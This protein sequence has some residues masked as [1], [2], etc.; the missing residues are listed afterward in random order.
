MTPPVPDVPRP[1]RQTAGPPTAG[2]R[3]A[4]ARTVL[5]LAVAAWVVLEIWLLTVVA[6]ALGGW[7]V[8]LL[9]LAGLVL[10]VAVVRRAGR[11]AWRR[12]AETVR[13]GAPQTPADRGGG[14]VTTMLGG[15]LLLLPG[16][17]SDVA[18]L[19]CLFPPTARLLRRAAERA[20]AGRSDPAPGTLG[21][22]LWQARTLREQARIHRP[23]GR[24]IRGETV[25]REE[26][27]PPEG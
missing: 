19:L 24:I 10:G 7:A 16:L 27:P 2:R 4:R 9:V 12:L 20:L 11:R 26:E 23:D 15:L 6:D 3:R 25:R 14:T 5:P 1:G 8:P 13:T 21:D 22:A 18:G 17:L